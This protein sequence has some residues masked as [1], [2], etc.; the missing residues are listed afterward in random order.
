MRAA[1]CQ[2]AAAQVEENTG[3]AGLFPR[4]PIVSKNNKS[5]SNDKQ[6]N[7][8]ICAMKLPNAMLLVVQ[9]I[10]ARVHQHAGASIELMSSRH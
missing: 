5:T 8:S 3:L 2:S 7:Q 10:D 9:K 4:K 1:N 6:K